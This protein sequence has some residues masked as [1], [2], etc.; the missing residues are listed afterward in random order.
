MHVMP[1][2]SIKTCDRR[3]WR[4]S[5]MGLRML[6]DRDWFRRV[7]LSCGAWSVSGLAA[8]FAEP[9]CKASLMSEAA[10]HLSRM[11]A[12]KLVAS[13][14]RLYF[15]ILALAMRFLCVIGVLCCHREPNERSACVC[16]PGGNCRGQYD[17]TWHCCRRCT[18]TYLT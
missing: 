12:R 15:R 8:F 17:W 14:W 9:H 13:R 3:R 11:F 10:V 5:I 16:Y 7:Y 2:V 18:G 4:G 6:G 1:N